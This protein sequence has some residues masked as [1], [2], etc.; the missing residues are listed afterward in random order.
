MKT[1]KEFLSDG[2]YFIDEIKEI[3][4]HGQDKH[5]FDADTMRFF[6]S[7]ISG[8]SWKIYG[9]DL[10]TLS[11]YFITSEKQNSIYFPEK[12]RLYTV[13][14]CDYKGNIEKISEFQQFESLND[15]RKFLYEAL[16]Q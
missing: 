1:F 3:V 4:K 12:R 10:T 9:W 15:A 16:K 13:R 2:N 14:S 6:S 11:Y 8:L 5:F 7:R